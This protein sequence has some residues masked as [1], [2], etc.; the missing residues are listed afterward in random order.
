[1]IESHPIPKIAV[2]AAQMVYA[3]KAE[4][5]AGIAATLN[6]LASET[7]EAMGLKPTDKWVVDFAAGHATRE[8]PDAVPDAPPAL[9]T[10]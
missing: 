3:R 5:E 4:F 1:M 10:P 8:V 6:Q 2:S 9:D 7:V